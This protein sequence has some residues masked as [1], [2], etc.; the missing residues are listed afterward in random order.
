MREPRVVLCQ[1]A[2]VEKLYDAARTL[3]A[4]GFTALDFYS[5]YPLPGSDEVLKLRRSPVPAIAAV[6][7]FTGVALAVLMQWWMNDVDYALNVGNRSAVPSPTWVPIMFELGVLLAG[8]AIFLG[9][10]A[11]FR[12]PQP[13]DPLFEVDAFRSATVDALWLSV[14]VEAGEVERVSSELRQ[15]GAS[16]VQ[17]V[18]EGA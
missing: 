7:G 6:A 15:L 9:L 14:K 12:F 8:I 17:L 5:P 2:S 3:Q 4:A 16:E 13:Y 1:V 18:P 10:L 11:L